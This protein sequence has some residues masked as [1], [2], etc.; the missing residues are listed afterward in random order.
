MS[1]VIIVMV[2]FYIVA[3]IAMEQDAN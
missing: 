1:F 2:A 3:V